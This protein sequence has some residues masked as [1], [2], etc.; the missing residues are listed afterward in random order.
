VAGVA[1]LPI[2]AGLGDELGRVDIWNLP[3]QHGRDS[4]SHHALLIPY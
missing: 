1:A 4:V 3:G 2:P